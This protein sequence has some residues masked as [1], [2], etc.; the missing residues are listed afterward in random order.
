M[1]GAKLRLAVRIAPPFQTP[2][3]RGA[4]HQ[5]ID[6]VIHYAQD[7]YSVDRLKLDHDRAS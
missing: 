4:A 1:L 7:L 3:D 5:D 2:G 6:G